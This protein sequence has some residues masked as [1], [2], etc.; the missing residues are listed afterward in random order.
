MAAATLD[1]VNE[2]RAPELAQGCPDLD[3]AGPARKV[4]RVLVGNAR[5]VLLDVSPAGRHRRAQRASIPREYKS[6]VI[7][8][9]EP[10]VR[11]RGPGIGGTYSVDQVSET[12]HGRRPQSEG[13]IDVD[14]CTL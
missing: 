4:W 8:N 2:A 14:P 6:A 9:V 11:V 10:L 12:W 5:L 13:A 3:S 1:Q 7:R